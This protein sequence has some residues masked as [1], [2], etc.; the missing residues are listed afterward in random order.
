LKAATVTKLTRNLFLAIVVPLLSYL[1]LRRLAAQG[2]GD[3]G[4]TIVMLLKQWPQDARVAEFR[5]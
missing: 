1:Y 2:A 3:G 4:K 5:G